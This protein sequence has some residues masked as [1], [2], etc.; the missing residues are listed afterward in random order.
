MAESGDKN[1]CKYKKYINMCHI[2][3]MVKNMSMMKRE[4]RYKTLKIS[5]YKIHIK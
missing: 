3:K 1:I 5:M 4:I 2:S